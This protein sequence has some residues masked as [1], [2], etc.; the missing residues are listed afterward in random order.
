MREKPHVM[1]KITPV[2]GEIGLPN[3]GLNRDHLAHVIN[4][5]HIVFHV[6]ASLK[7]EANLKYNLEMNL[8]G[9]KNTIDLAKQ[10]K[11]L[12]IFVHTST[13]FCNVELET[14]EEK[15]Y[16]YP[17]DPIE[18]IQECEPLN[19]KMLEKIQD[20][21]MGI[22][23]NTYTYTKRLAEILVR[24]EYEKNNFPCIILRPSIV[25]PSY[26]EPVEG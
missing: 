14:I 4:N 12:V 9:T 23:P 1:S 6:A 7:L 3:L 17:Q 8:I 18:V 24:N 11:N 20:E 22:H 10:M 25:T 2:Y 16:D 19:E 5:S 13:A 21:Y 15:I 26:K